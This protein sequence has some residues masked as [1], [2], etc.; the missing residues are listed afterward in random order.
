MIKEFQENFII[1]FPKQ[2]EVRPEVKELI[3]KCLIVD[4]EKRA[5]W[6]DLFSHAIFAG[7]VENISNLKKRFKYILGKIRSEINESNIDLNEFFSLIKSQK[8]ELTYR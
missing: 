8:N 2:P 3:K 5:D 4:E 6:D 1:E 7:R